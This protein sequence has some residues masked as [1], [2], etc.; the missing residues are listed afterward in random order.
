MC[1]VVLLMA[2]LRMETQPEMVDLGDD[3]HRIW[4]GGTCW[5]EW[6]K[7]WIEMDMDT[8]RNRKI[9]R[10]VGLNHICPLGKQTSSHRLFLCLFFL[11]ATH[12]K[13]FLSFFSQRK[14]LPHL[15]KTHFLFLGQKTLCSGDF[16]LPKTTKKTH[17]RHE[18][19]HRLGTFAPSRRLEA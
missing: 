8:K 14:N 15:K 17:A 1:L 5:R 3:Q 11:T 12:L 4:G 6:W 9:C 2:T 7:R 16:F 13:C 19:P 18:T 10:T